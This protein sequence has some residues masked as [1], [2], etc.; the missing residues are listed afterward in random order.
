MTD[1]DHR[2]CN[3]IFQATKYVLGKLPSDFVPNKT[4]QITG[5]ESLAELWILSKMNACAKEINQAIPEREFM[6]ATGASY[7]YWYNQLCDVYIENSKALIQDG[8]DAEKQSATQTLYTALEA[9]LTMIH[10]FMPFLTEEL[11][12]RLPRRPD[13]K[14]PSIMLAQ[15]PV[16]RA[17]LDSP[18]AE[19]AYEQVLGSSKGIRSLMAEYALKDEAKGKSHRTTFLTPQGPS[20]TC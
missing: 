2:F 13:D 19:A 15:Y 17:E 3:K 6:K 10:P 4:V 16:Y 5:Q 14:T 7:T 18:E 9:A 12:Q 1:H 11:W 20:A 8:T